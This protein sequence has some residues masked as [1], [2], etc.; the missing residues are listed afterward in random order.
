M[1]DEKIIKILSLFESSE[2]AEALINILRNSGLI[3]R[4]SR[5]EDEEDLLAF[6]ENETTDLVIAKSDS[7]LVNLKQTLTSLQNTGI[8]LPLIVITPAKKEN[9]ALELLSLGARDIVAINNYERFKAIIK[10][11]ASDL[12]QRRSSRRFEKLLHEAEKRTKSLIESSRD[13]I[14]YIHEGMH[15]Y[16]NQA[17][18]NIFGHESMDD[19]EGMPILDM[20]DND[21]HAK[22][23]DYLRKYAKGQV[24]ENKLEVHAIKE[25]GRRSTVLLEFAPA[26]MDGEICTQ[27]IIRDQTLNT[28]LETKLNVLS[29]QDLLTGLYNRKY[30]IEQLDMFIAQTLNGND[31]GAILLFT[32]DDYGKIK[33]ESGISGS[34]M[35]LADIGGIFKEKLNDLGELARFDGP[36]F[37]LLLKHID[38][39]KINKITNGICKIVQEHYSDVAGKSVNTTCSI[40]VALINETTASAEECVLRAESG[41]KIAHKDGGNQAHLFNPAIEDLGENEQD[42][43]WNAKIK[44]ALRNNNFSLLFQPIVSLHGESGQHYEILIRMKD[45]DG[46]IILPSEFL[47]TA[48]RL[49]LTMY[50]DRWILGNTMVTLAEQAKNKTQTRFFIKISSGSIADDDFLLWVS[51][52]IKSLRIN[53]DDLVFEFS[54]DTALNYLNRVK[55]IITGLKQLN[56]RVAIENF[57]KEPNAFQALKQLDFDYIKIHGDLIKNLASNVEMQERVKEIAEFCSNNNKQTIASFVEN[58]NNLAVLWQCSIDFIQGYF[59]QEPKTELTYDFDEGF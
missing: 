5:V 42:S 41:M 56:C 26:S 3:I 35:L 17:Y 50:I 59:L 36:I 52:R 51:E 9:E 7:Q 48:E 32:L 29:Q 30:F 21:D 6:L 40:G 43:H 57:G 2:E 55:T 16:V 25:S 58:A 24:K 10:R 39:K 18:L 20:V 15:I 38:S 4:D 28:E 33:D 54:E 44:H 49:G 22:F 34:D 45:D 13:A 53:T 37:S 31:R 27:L 23:K 47:S 12:I 8:D 11:E 46:K 14:A 19:V 1:N